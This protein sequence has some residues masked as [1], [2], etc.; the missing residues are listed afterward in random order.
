MRAKRQFWKLTGY[1]LPTEAEW[2]FACRAGTNTSRYYG[3]ASELLPEYAWYGANGT[4]HSRPV[5]MLKPNDFGLFDMHGNV[6]EWNHGLLG[7]YATTANRLYEDAPFNDRILAVGAR[8][9]RGGSF[10]SVHTS[11]RCAARN[12]H[13]PYRKAMDHG[14]RPARTFYSSPRPSSN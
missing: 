1:R 11:I 4:D 5:G 8:A 6:E 7:T 3:Q 14:F 2:E 9:M 10:L 12:A 13:Y